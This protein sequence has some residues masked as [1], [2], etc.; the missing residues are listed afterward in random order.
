MLYYFFLI[1][2]IL[3]D[4]CYSTSAIVQ[5][6]NWLTDFTKIIALHNGYD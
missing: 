2:N 1:F 4:L 5:C 3:I 6:N